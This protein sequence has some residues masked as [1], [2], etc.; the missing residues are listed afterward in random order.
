MKTRL[1]LLFIVV[2][3]WVSGLVVAQDVSSVP[4]SGR[5]AYIGTDYNVY[6]MSAK[7]ST[8]LTQDGSLR[9]AYQWLTWS[10]DGRLAYF[11]CDL[12]LAAQLETT[13]YI[14]SDGEQ[15]GRAVLATR[16]KP[17]IYAYWSPSRCENVDT[18]RDLVIL[19]NDVQNGGLSVQGIRHRG[20]T[21]ETFEIGTGAPFYYSFSPTGDRLLFHRN[22][23]AID[24]YSLLEGRVTRQ[25]REFSSGAFQAPSWSPIDDRLLVGVQGARANT[26][27][28]VLFEGDSGRRTLLEGIEGFVSF[29]WSPDGK[30]IAYRA[31]SSQ[32]HGK[33]NVLN[34]NTGELVAEDN[35]GGVVA[36]FWSPDSRKI[37]SIS[38][39]TNRTRADAG[40][41]RVAQGR[42]IQLAWAILDVT[43]GQESVLEA[44]RPTYEMLYIMNYFDQ[45]AQSHRFW[46]PD[47]RYLVYSALTDAS[48]NGAIQ[49]LDIDGT[50]SSVT[51]AEGVFAVWSFE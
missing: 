42:D 17:I 22:N 34:A 48:P 37:A 24:V 49:L 6:S 23:R 33:L 5:I 3:A 29:L 15:A 39:R 7:S 9:R 45:F 21:S 40:T 51:I 50:A 4:F 2:V 16:A 26:T 8:Q 18:C 10:E 41:V 14:S 25:I 27:D 12:R 38:L 28:L 19:V 46:S 20:D 30:F 47:S 13:A 32:G 31:I 35:T 11:C 43:T 44:F 36:F 1:W